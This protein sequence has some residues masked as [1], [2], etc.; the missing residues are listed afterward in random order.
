MISIRYYV[1]HERDG[2]MNISVDPKTATLKSVFDAIVEKEGLSTFSSPEEF[3]ADLEKQFPCENIKLRKLV[4]EEVTRLIS[5]TRRYQLYVGN[6]RIVPEF[7][8]MNRED[9]NLF[10]KYCEFQRF[11][12]L[13]KGLTSDQLFFCVKTIPW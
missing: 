6:T 12:S 2:T 7:L 10:E 4:R 1:D 5:G 13:Y 11:N 3:H 9:G 8:C